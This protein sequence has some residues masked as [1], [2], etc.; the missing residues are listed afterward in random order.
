MPAQ[1]QKKNPTTQKMDAYRSNTTHSPAFEPMIQEPCSEKGDQNFMYVRGH[2]IVELHLLA[3]TCNSPHPV[4]ATP[5]PDARRASA[6]FQRHHLAAYLLTSPSPEGCHQT[7]GALARPA[8]RSCTPRTLTTAALGRPAGK[9]C[10][11]FDDRRSV[12]VMP[13]LRRYS[14]QRTTILVPILYVLI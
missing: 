10:P 3:I 14:A 8:A 13:R 6:M 4:T 12:P 5:I 9:R 7:C 2:G 1:E 11:Q